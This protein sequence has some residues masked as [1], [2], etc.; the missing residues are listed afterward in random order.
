M[1]FPNHTVPVDKSYESLL[2]GVLEKEEFWCWELKSKA[3]GMAV[4]EVFALRLWKTRESEEMYK[5]GPS[6]ALLQLQD[7]GQ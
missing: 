3:D 4:T 7:G 5:T 2:Q 1:F 6:T